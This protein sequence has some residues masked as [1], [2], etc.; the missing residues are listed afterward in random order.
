MKKWINFIKTGWER[1]FSKHDKRGIMLAGIN[2]LEILKKEASGMDCKE[3]EIYIKHK[4]SDE[5]ILRKMFK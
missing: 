5:E 4:E 1:L 2:V 3:K